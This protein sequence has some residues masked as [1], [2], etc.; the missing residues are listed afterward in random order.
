[1]LVILYLLLYSLEL[2]PIEKQ[3]IH[4]K[5]IKCSTH[6]SIEALFSITIHSELAIISLIT[7]HSINN[8]IFCAQ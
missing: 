1:M 3:S 4:A 8:G 2:N 5:Q 7:A 6:C